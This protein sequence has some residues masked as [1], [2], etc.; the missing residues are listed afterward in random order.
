MLI[1]V[2]TSCTKPPVTGR[3]V[4]FSA[5]VRDRMSQDWRVQSK[6]QGFW[7]ILEDSI[8]SWNILENYRI[9]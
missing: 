2:L 4:M 7:K 5:M 1:S 9:F 8:R 3:Q 6:C